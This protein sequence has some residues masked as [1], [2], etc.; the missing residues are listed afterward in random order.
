MP[1][2]TASLLFRYSPWEMVGISLPTAWGG[3]GWG[4]RLLDRRSVGGKLAQRLGDLVR[5]GH[6]EVLLR[7]I[8]RH[9]RD[10]RGRDPHDR[11]VQAVE[12]VLGDDRGDL[13]AESSREVVLVD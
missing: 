2:A 4:L 9:R 6:E 3:P 12:G 11:P 8:E 7:P 13:R 10:I 5:A 1:A